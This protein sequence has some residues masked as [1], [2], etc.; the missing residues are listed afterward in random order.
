MMK[1]ALNSRWGDGMDTNRFYRQSFPEGPLISQFSNTS[2]RCHQLQPTPAFA[3]CCPGPY[4]RSGVFPYQRWSDDINHH[5]KFGT[6]LCS[7]YNKNKS[8]RFAQPRTAPCY[9]IWWQSLS[10]A[11][12]AHLYVA[13]KYASSVLPY[14]HEEHQ[15]PSAAPTNV[16]PQA[17]LSGRSKLIWTDHG[18]YIFRKILL[19]NQNQ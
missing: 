12:F 14:S 9:H 2:S 1:L 7:R 8:G 11:S 3:L 17:N 19:K 6:E 5:V 4:W 16:Q 18:N 13:M 15:L 10:S